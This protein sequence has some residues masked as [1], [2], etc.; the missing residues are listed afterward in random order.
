MPDTWADILRGALVEIGAKAPGEDL[1]SD[2]EADAFVRLQG[3]FDEWGLEGLLVPGLQIVSHKFTESDCVFT[4]G[5]EGDDTDIVTSYT[6]EEIDSLN[7]KRAGATRA[8]PIDPTSY[9]VLSEIRRSYRYRPQKYYYDQSYPLARLH[10]DAKTEPDD[11]IE[12]AGTGHFSSDFVVGDDPG[13]ILPKGYREAVLLNIAVKLAPSYGV[14]D[15]RSQGLSSQTVRGARIG[16]SKIMSRNLQVVESP[17][18]P[19]LAHYSTSLLARH[20]SGRR[21]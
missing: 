8:H 21:R 17:I 15:G 12:I 18:D 19:A 4:I 7:Y 14:K 10:F 5:P 6:I 3:M 16:K 13:L 20:D 2:E 9:A 11:V 1:D